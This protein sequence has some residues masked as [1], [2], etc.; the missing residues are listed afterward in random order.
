MK[1][2]LIQF[3]VFV[4]F[5]LCACGNNAANSSLPCNVYELI[6]GFEYWRLPDSDMSIFSGKA[7]HIVATHYGREFTTSND[8]LFNEKGNILSITH[9]G[10]DDTSTTNYFYDNGK[11]SHFDVINDDT[12]SVIKKFYFVKMKSGKQIFELKDFLF[13]K[14]ESCSIEFNSNSIRVDIYSDSNQFESGTKWTYNKNQITS[15]SDFYLSIP[16]GPKS[17]VSE[18]YKTTI[19]YTKDGC[20]SFWK[21]YSIDNN[22][23]N[24][25]DSCAYSYSDSRLISMHHIIANDGSSLDYSFKNWDEYGNWHEMLDSKG[26]IIVSRQIEYFKDK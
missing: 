1:H 14:I 23:M 21:R 4:L 9:D 19:E 18:Q 8:F 2:S 26:K 22:N 6:N 17:V 24:I 15:I 7:R 3:S 11:F 5:L 16:I 25:I 20:I 12:K 13:G 10:L